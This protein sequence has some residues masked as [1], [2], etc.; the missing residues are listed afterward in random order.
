[1][2]V[3]TGRELIVAGGSTENGKVLRDGAA[4]FPAT[5]K[6]RRLPTMPQPRSGSTLVWDGREVLF[7]GGNEGG[8]G[9]PDRTGL[10][11]SP[12][13]S[14]WRVLPAMHYRRKGFAAVWTGRDVLV[15]GGLSGQPGHWTAPARGE[16]YDP[17]T[18]RWLLMPVGPLH[19]RMVT[20][21]VWTGRQLIVW[22]GF[23]EHPGST[24]EFLDGA[25]F[26]PSPPPPGSRR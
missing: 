19:S 1:M 5:N 3:W 8:F 26:T 20:A 14:R 15:W 10:A 11:Y 12:T 4:Y 2:T 23:I 22:G 13:A 6:W 9:L 21:A 7:L 17:A 24:T 16:A 25:A 18:G